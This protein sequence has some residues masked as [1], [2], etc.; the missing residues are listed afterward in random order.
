M[1]R[2]RLAAARARRR[3]ASSRAADQTPHDRL[4]RRRRGGGA[5]R[6]CA[7]P[8]R[9]R[10]SWLHSTRSRERDRRPACGPEAPSWPR[11]RAVVDELCATRPARLPCAAQ[12][13][14]YPALLDRLREMAAAQLGPDAESSVDPA[15]T[16]DPRDA[17]DSADRLLAATSSIAAVD[18][19]GDRVE[20]LWR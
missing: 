10:G 3:R 13:R 18:G 9:A 8:R 5:G 12:I 11:E 4:A 15:G 7:T 19:L 2:S 20:E 17:P 14:R 6:A 16:R 1:R